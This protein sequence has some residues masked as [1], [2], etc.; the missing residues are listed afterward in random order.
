MF[1]QRHNIFFILFL[2]ELSRIVFINKTLPIKALFQGGEEK[3][4]AEEARE[5]GDGGGGKGGAGAQEAEEEEERGEEKGG[6][7]RSKISINSP[8]PSVCLSC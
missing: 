2:T 4:E 1:L 8:V 3:G 5:G 7:L 6:I